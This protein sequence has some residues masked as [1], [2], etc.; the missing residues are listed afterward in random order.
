MPTVL[1]SGPYRLFFYSADGLEAPHVHVERDDKIAK[2]WL[3]PVR[4][5]DSGGFGRVEIRRLEAIVEE[6]VD[7]LLRSWDEFFVG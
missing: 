3:R 4:L 6:N 5:A 2:F 1:R 7:V